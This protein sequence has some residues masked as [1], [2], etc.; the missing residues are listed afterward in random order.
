MIEESR[1]LAEVTQILEKIEADCQQNKVDIKTIGLKSLFLALR[2]CTSQTTL[3]Q[4]AKVFGIGCNLLIEKLQRIQSFI[5]ILEDPEK[6]LS[7]FSTQFDFDT[8]AHFLAPCLISQCDV[9]G[10]SVQFLLSSLARLKNVQYHPI[11][12]SPPD[13]PSPPQDYEILLPAKRFELLKNE[14]LAEI[15]TSNE[16]PLSEVLQGQAIPE[17]YYE[18]FMAIL[19]LIQD[20]SIQYISSNQTLKVETRE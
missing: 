6:I 14:I 9:T 20:G 7:F 11:T 2:D 4:V 17:D 16:L 13:T 19:H 1:N 3:D 15:A 8:S 10:V 12:I 18:T 5:Q